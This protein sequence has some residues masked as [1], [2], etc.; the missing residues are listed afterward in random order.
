MHIDEIK[1]EIERTKLVTLQAGEIIDVSFAS[2]SYFIDNI[3]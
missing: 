3:W 2:Q 1:D